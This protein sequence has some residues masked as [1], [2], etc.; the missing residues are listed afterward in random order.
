MKLALR[1]LEDFRYD[2]LRM[3]LNRQLGGETLVTL[4]LKGRNPDL[5]DGYPIALNLTLSGALDR[6]LQ[7]SLSG[8]RVP[9]KIRQRMLDFA[10]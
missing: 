10:Q 6:I 3:T 9:D 8:Y 2:S 4:H 5:Y 7:D 1:A